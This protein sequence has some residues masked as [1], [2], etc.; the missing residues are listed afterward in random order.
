MKATAKVGRCARL[1]L[2]GAVLRAR[3]T[4]RIRDMSQLPSLAQPDDIA[5]RLGRTLNQVEAARVDSLLADGS[6]V[7]RRYCRR[8]FMYHDTDTITM[9]ADGGIIKLTSWRPIVSI[10]E[11]LAL[12]GTPGIL[13]IPVTWYHFDAVDKITVFNPAYS[14]IINLPEMW[15]EETFWWGGSFRITG[16]HGFVDT[17]DDV[18][19]VLCTAVTSELSTPT[20]SATLMSESVGAYSYSMRRTSGAGLNAALIDAGMKTVLQ[21]YRQSFGTMKTRLL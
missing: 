9:V 13:D 20:M 2:V 4:R 8:D 11:V 1:T 6:A 16:A 5:A 10:D 15:Y 7:L 21:D 19:S 17:P 18:V 12:S 14:G 3:R